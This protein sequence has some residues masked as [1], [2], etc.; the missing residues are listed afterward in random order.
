MGRRSHT[1]DHPKFRALTAES[2]P[3]AISFCC[4]DCGSDAQGQE[5]QRMR[6]R[7]LEILSDE[8]YGNMPMGC[9]PRQAEKF[10][11]EAQDRAND[12]VIA[13]VRD[14][15]CGFPILAAISIIGFLWK[16]WEIFSAW[17]W[18]KT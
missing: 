15:A 8:L 11:K 1:A 17:M 18:P 9:S 7:G 13:E 6:A 2:L 3:D 5:E 16:L 12:R 14:P 10:V 4:G